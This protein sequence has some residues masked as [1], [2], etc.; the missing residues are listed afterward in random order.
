[1]FEQRERIEDDLVD[2]D[3]RELG[4]AGTREVEQI[5]DDFGR[6]ESLARDLFEQ[7]RFLGITLQ[8]LGEHL[9]VRRD[10]GKG[11]IN[12]VSHAGCQQADRR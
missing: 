8:L 1:M 3:V 2:V 11:C 5:V 4:A 9:R 7:S 12:F 6:P 10:D